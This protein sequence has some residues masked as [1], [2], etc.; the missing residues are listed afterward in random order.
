V[1]AALSL[2]EKIVV[3]SILGVCIAALLV[4][5]VFQVKLIREMRADLSKG[6]RS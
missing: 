5:I 6:R 4:S 1:I 3:E 2:T